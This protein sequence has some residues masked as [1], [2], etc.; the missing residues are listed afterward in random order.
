MLGD[1][2]SLACDADGMRTAY[3]AAEGY[4]EELAYELGAVDLRHGRLLVAAGAQRPAAWA[5]NIWLDPQTI[6]IASIS[7]AAHKLRAIQRNWA[8]YAPHLHRRADPTAA[9]QSIRPAA[10]VR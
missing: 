10:R 4:E 7:D 1:A 9:A 6:V 2:P 3:L 5:A 8:L